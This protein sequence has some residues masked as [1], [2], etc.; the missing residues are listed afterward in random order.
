[1]KVTAWQAH[2][3]RGFL[4]GTLG[5]KL[6]LSVKSAKREDGEI[7]EWPRVLERVKS[8]YDHYRA[9]LERNVMDA[10]FARKGVHGFL[11]GE[12]L[13]RATEPGQG[14]AELIAAVRKTTT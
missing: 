5:K 7:L 2:S 1:M 6:G 10:A 11:L 9:L 8:Q 13:M 12:S 14:L 3:V 4:S